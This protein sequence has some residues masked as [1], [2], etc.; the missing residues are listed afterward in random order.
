MDGHRPGITSF[1]HIGLVVE[2]LDE[3]VRFLELL[4]LDCSEP[5]AFSGEW[6]ERLDGTP[7]QRP[8]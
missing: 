2:D 8:D 4:G 5:G 7:T 6:I 1:V 3:T